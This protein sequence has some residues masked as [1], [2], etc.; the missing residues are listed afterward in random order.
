LKVDATQME[1]LDP[2]I[3]A[4]WAKEAGAKQIVTAYVPEGPL[5]DWLRKAEPALQ[6]AEIPLCEWQRDWDANIWP[7]ATAGFFKV[8]QKIPSILSS[9]EIF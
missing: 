3:L 4:S 2:M 6:E 9:L 1:C 7:S 5:R 8:K